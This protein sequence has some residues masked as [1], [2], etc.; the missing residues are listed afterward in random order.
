MSERLLFVYGTLREGLGNWRWALRGR[1]KK[2]GDLLL[3]GQYKMYDLGGFPGVVV[4]PESYG[5]LLGEVY[6]VPEDVWNEI[7]Y[8]EGYPTLFGRKAVKTP[9]G[10]AEMYVYNGP[11]TGRTEVSGGDWKKWIEVR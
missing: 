3:S 10:R 1:A 5:E 7:E 2:L 8:L 11:V 9:W 4:I 6:S